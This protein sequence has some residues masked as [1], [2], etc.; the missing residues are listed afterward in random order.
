MEFGGESQMKLS[1]YK[2]YRF[3]FRVVACLMGR[4]MPN[5]WSQQLR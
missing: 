3:S 5:N 2:W 1:T 4:D